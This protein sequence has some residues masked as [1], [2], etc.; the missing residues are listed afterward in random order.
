MQIILQMKNGE[1]TP[2]LQKMPVYMSFNG[3]ISIFTAMKK[4][5]SC[6]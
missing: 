6:D 4:E 2:S 3:N 5:I 1:N